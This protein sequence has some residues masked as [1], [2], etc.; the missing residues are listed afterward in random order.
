MLLVVLIGWQLLNLC[1]MLLKCVCVFVQPL[2]KLGLYCKEL[3]ELNLHAAPLSF[4]LSCALEAKKTGTA[5]SFSSFPAF[6]HF[7]THNV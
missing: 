6:F 4:A 1:L 3:Q 7:Y 2:E 5:N